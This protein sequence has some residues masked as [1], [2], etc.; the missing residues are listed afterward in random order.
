VRCA[1]VRSHISHTHTLTHTHTH[2]HTHTNLNPDAVNRGLSEPLRVK[3][4]AVTHT[5]TCSSQLV[6]NKISLSRRTSPA[7]IIHN[8]L[9]LSLFLYLSQSHTHI[10]PL[11]QS[12]T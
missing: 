7:V 8:S 3:R 11:P 12:H 5:S 1:Q 9:S 2:T 10:H 4:P 6:A